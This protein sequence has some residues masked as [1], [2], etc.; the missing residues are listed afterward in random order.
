MKK[1]TIILAGLFMLLAVS[2]KKD[3]PGITISSNTWKMGEYK[4]TKSNGTQGA[5]F[6]NY[7]LVMM[8]S[9]KTTDGKFVG[10]TLTISF[11]NKGEGEYNIS[12]QRSQLGDGW[13]M[14]LVGSLMTGV[15]KMANYEV[16]LPTTVK[17]KVKKDDKGKYHI[18]ISQPLKMVKDK[19]NTSPDDKS[20]DSFM[21]T[22]NDLY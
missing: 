6:E 14:H 4:F 11:V 1:L 9:D 3:N 10:S 8:S 16:E 18:T 13:D 5:M 20:P 7:S 17:A 19:T 15:A 2:C 21:M 12:D 22:I